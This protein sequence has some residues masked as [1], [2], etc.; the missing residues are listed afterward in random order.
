MVWGLRSRIKHDF[1]RLPLLLRID[2]DQSKP[3]FS[4]NF[5]YTQKQYQLGKFSAQSVELFKVIVWLLDESL[6]FFY[7]PE[8]ER[9]FFELEHTEGVLAWHQKP[10]GLHKRDYAESKDIER[11]LEEFWR[12]LWLDVDDIILSYDLL[13]L[14]T[15]FFAAGFSLSSLFIRVELSFLLLQTVHGKLDSVED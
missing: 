8:N 4:E 10:L 9:V 11:D 3:K 14:L 6:G 2:M 5:L 1:S 7:T 12:V 15:A 13:L